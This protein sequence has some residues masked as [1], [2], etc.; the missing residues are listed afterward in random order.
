MKY[1]CWKDRLSESSIQNLKYIFKKCLIDIWD[2]SIL[3]MVIY[4]WIPLLF[5]FIFYFFKLFVCL[6]REFTNIVD[7]SIKI[8]VQCLLVFGNWGHQVLSTLIITEKGGCHCFASKLAEIDFNF[9]VVI[10]DLLSL[11]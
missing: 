1:N 7:V 6:F 11:L 2:M 10:S 5:I 4:L 8:S 3:S 9:G